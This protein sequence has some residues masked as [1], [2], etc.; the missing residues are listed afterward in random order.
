[1]NVKLKGSDSGSA[2]MR[3][4]NVNLNLTTRDVIGHMV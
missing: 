1:M 2:Q 3:A 4:V